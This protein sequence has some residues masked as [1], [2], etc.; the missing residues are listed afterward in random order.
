MNILRKLSLTLLLALPLAVTAAPRPATPFT[1]AEIDQLL[2]PIALYPDTVLSHVLIAATVP[3]DVA[4]A[5]DWIERHPDL[6][7]QEAVDAVERYDWDPSVKALVAFPE[8]IE[9][10]DEDPDWT[11]DLGLA[12]LEQEETVMDRVQVLRDRAYENGS[13]DDLEHV[14]VVREREYIYI[15]PA[16]S[17]VVYVPYYDPWYVYGAWWWPSYPPYRWTYWAGR[18][19]HYY[20]G[21]AFWWGVSYHVGPTWYVGSFNWPHRHVVVTRPHR[22]YTPTPGYSGYSPGRSHS[23]R[24]EG[25]RS[26]TRYRSDTRQWRDDSPGG[27]ASR[28]RSHGRDGAPVRRGHDR[29]DEGDTHVPQRQRAP[30]RDWTEVRAGLAARREASRD[31]SHGA[32]S[33]G[34]APRRDDSAAD[35][36][37]RRVRDVEPGRRGAVRAETRDRSERRVLDRAPER[38][39]SRPQQRVESRGEPRSEAQPRV[40]PRGE[41]RAQPRVEPRGETRAQPRGD[42]RGSASPRGES[43]GG[44][45]GGDRGN[46][47]GSRVRSR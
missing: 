41:V 43:R 38:P 34:A 22:H 14:R 29:H 37:D 20:Y 27:S 40:E 7:G 33:R 6:R 44:G 39:V 5:A 16:V 36:V 8:V 11:G 25:A 30:R 45:R 17:R 42:T 28:G 18:P 15:E 12:F 26:V 2:A 31:T 32:V 47:G 24:R 46:G 21:S 9:R 13:L 3:D 10:M 4:R 19:A 35:R 23:M 1:D